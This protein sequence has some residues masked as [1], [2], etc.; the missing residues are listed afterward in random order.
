MIPQIVLSKVCQYLEEREEGFECDASIWASL[1]VRGLHQLLH[2]P[3]R[4]VLP[5]RAEDF[6]H[7]GHLK[8]KRQ[9][10]IW[11]QVLGIF[12]RGSV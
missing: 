2:V 1:A 8:R 7:L 11:V 10:N 4:G 5:Q 9:V 6:P 3:L 12:S